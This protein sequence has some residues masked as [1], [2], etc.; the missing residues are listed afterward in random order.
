[1]NERWGDLVS[2][3]CLAGIRA[4]DHSAKNSMI[5]SSKEAA[6]RLSKTGFLRWRMAVPHGS[7]HAVDFHDLTVYLQTWTTWRKPWRRWTEK[8]DCVSSDWNLIH[9]FSNLATFPCTLKTMSEKNK[10]MTLCSIWLSPPGTS[11]SLFPNSTNGRQ[12]L[13][14]VL[15]VNVFMLSVWAICPPKFPFLL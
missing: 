11:T 5:L 2:S 15:Q 4:T 13:P 8:I 1:M 14:R 6:A 3:T 9:N 12:N 7:K 10:L